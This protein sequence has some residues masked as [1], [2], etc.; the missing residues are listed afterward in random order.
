MVRYILIG[1]SY[2]LSAGLQPGPL[3]AFF[4]AKVVENG[5]RR[6]LPAAF[7][8][9]VSDGPIALVALGILSYLPDS[10]QEMLQI[11]GGITLLFFAWSSLRRW[12]S[13]QG[14]VEKKSSST[15]RT[16]LQAALVNLLNPNPYLGWSLVMGP[17]VIIAW[18]DKPF[19][20]V[21]L[22]GTFYLVMISTSL[23]LITLMGTTSLL[24]PD[25][26]RTL[27]LIS[28]LLLAG[29][30]F[31]YLGSGGWRLIKSF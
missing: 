11:A 23:I 7:A 9:L 29:L 19:Y 10:F 15:P 28:A 1:A 3:Q 22:L 6:T 24:N 14:S 16:F 2:A 27:L 18:D 17:A 4:L 30:G 25:G 21:L 5:W 13:G 12:K 26:Q 20:A 8:P 31:Y